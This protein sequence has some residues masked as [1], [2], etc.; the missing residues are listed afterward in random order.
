MSSPMRVEGEVVMGGE[1]RV[2]ITPGQTRCARGT[3]ETRQ[4]NAGRAGHA[5]RCL[6]TA[7][8]LAQHVVQQVAQRNGY[9]QQFNATLPDM[10]IYVYGV[11]LL[12]FRRQNNGFP[13]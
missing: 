11:T 2:Y 5:L 13:P 4:K 6:H 1:G 10:T 9:A 8:H 12:W 3:L 7:Q